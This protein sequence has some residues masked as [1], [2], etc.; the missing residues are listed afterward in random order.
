MPASSSWIISRPS[1]AAAARTKPRVG[2]RSRAGLSPGDARTSRCS[3]FITPA[4]AARSRREDVLD[5][6]VN[7]RRPEDYEQGAR[8]E[9]HF[10]K[11]RG[12]MGKDAEPFEATLSDDLWLNSN[13]GT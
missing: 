13:K 6:V 2:G 3:S 4:R 1:V 9:V 11:S 12:F 10:D 8:F 5:T 7:L